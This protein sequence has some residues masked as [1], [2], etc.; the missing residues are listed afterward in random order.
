M[1]RAI[2]IVLTLAACGTPS[3]DA[4]T[5]AVA[6]AYPLA[7]L[8][9]EIAPD[10]ELTSLA[11][12][13]QDPHD[14]E[15]TPKQRATLE[16]AGL[17][18]Y[19]GDIGFQPQVEAAVP[20]AQGEVVSVADVLGEDRLRPIA[21]GHEEED[22]HEDEAEHSEEAEH[23]EEAD[24]DEGGID[25]HFW[26]D[27]SLM[28]DVATAV[29]KAAGAADPARAD[30]YARNAA[31]TAGLLDD[32]AGEIEA[33]LSSC[34]ADT[35]IVSHEAYQYLLAPAGLEQHGISGAAGHSEASPSDIADLAAEIRADGLPAVLTEPVEGRTDAE[36]VAA[37]AG[38]DLI[39][40]YSLDVVDEAQA[41]K[42]F[43]QLLREQADAVAQAAGCAG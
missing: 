10:L 6:T 37:E 39:E 28:A 4:G 14:L 40:I 12:R 5:A 16:T 34:S 43:P 3:A 9:G 11:A 30:E 20:S 23:D 36:A 15:L 25:P 38:V 22:E 13:G 24:H 32:L 18:V 19:L 33:T 8:A 42:G 17:V 35:V 41:A 27:A 26:F 1:R 7:W 2:L 31:T 21:D 29:G